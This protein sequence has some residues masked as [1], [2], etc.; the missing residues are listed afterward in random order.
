[1]AF[2]ILHD[3]IIIILM[4]IG[5]QR[6]NEK[7]FWHLRYRTIKKNKTMFDT[8]AA[9]IV[10][11]IVAIIALPFI[12]INLYKKQRDLNFI[13]E[14]SNMAEKENIVISKRE[15]LN[16]C[17]AIGIDNH[18]GKLLYINKRNDEAENVIIELSEVDKCRIANINKTFK[19]QD[20]KNNLSDRI[21]LIFT[22]SR[23]DIPEKALEFYYS[24]EFMPTEKEQSHAENWLQIINSNLKVNKAKPVY[25]I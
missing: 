20:G 7:Q 10:L 4:Q 17:Y 1:M 6:F 9:I 22:F 14:F 25:T 11:A 13:K 3:P 18:S 16:N 5:F 19:T 24:K 23:S 15:I 8:G 12:F 2:P 21:E